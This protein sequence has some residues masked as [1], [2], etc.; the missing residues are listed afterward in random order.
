VSLRAALPFADGAFDCWLREPAVPESAI[1]EPHWRKWHRVPMF[2]H[3]RA[4]K[5]RG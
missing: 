2:L 4:V 1:G 5:P 3:G